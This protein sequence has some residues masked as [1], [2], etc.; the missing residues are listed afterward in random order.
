MN[1]VTLIGRLTADPEVKY[2]QGE[3]PTA[4]AK[5]TLAVNRRFKKEGE[6]DADFIRCTAF[7][8]SGEFA[9][10]YLTKGT[11]IAVCGRIQTGSYEKEDGQK[12]FT[13][14]VIAEEH[15][16]CGSKASAES[17]SAPE[18]AM[19]DMPSIPGADDDDLPF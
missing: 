9:E 5:Y 19:P 10:K 18:A 16:F 13:T 2:T 8:K 3:K 4:I 6:Q 1:K 15:Y 7:G 17:A 12:V 14:D 11:Q